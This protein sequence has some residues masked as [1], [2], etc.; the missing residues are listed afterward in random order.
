MRF[1]KWLVVVLVVLASA[2]WFA[3][4][5]A[6]ENTVETALADARAQG[7]TAE[8][9]S[10]AVGGFPAALDLR[11]TSL[12]L[13]DPVS[14]AGWQAPELGVSAPI[15]A[16]WDL[17]AALPPDQLLSL[18]DQGITLTSDNLLLALTS[19]PDPDLPLRRAWF[20][21]TSLAATSDLG[22]TL[23]FGEISA[24]LTAD[25]DHGPAAYALVFDLAP[26][27]PD[28][29]LLQTLSQV[30]IPDL[31]PSDL[32]PEVDRIDGQLRLRLTAPLDRHAGD[33]NPQVQA[34]EMSSVDL[35]WGALTLHAEGTVEA[36]DAGYA[37]GRILLQLRGWDRLPALLVATGTIKP[38][39]AP[40][41][42]GFLRAIAAESPDPDVLALPLKMEGGRMSLGPFPLGPAPMLRAPLG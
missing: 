32:P 31:P 34:I 36:D 7:K 29:L 33:T 38:E 10:V 16:P 1:L 4:K 15:W 30:A 2:G 40:T 11:I 12:H 5:L 41:I 3:A 21:A 35:G 20:S 18:P 13:A 22:W 28:P 17:S 26:L 6:I 14:G 42:H 27:S 8:A 19:A 24:A 9:S 39:V 25:P 23:G 37:S